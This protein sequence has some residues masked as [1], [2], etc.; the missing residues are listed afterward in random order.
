MLWC[1][2]PLETGKTCRDCLRHTNWNI[3]IQER[4]ITMSE[5]RIMLL[6]ILH[7]WEVDM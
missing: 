2:T 1:S 4:T 3:L 5:D 7:G 6:C